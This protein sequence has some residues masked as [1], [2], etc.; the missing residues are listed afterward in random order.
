MCSCQC[1]DNIF[2]KILYHLLFKENALQ[3][4]NDRNLCVGGLQKSLLKGL[5]ALCC[6]FYCLV[7]K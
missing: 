3:F 6:G 7:I 4:C 2:L 5:A 1:A